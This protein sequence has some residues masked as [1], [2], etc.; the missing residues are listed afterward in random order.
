MFAKHD[1]LLILPQFQNLLKSISMSEIY[2]AALH[3]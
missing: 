1:N 2:A 3:T